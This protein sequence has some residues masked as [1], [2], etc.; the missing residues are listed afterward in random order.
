MPSILLIEDDAAIRQ[1]LTAR[2]AEEGFDVDAASTG[3][4]GL[5]YV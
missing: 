2:L 4:G 3:I 1:T 5:S